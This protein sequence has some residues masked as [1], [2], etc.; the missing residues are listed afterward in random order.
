M[1]RAQHRRAFAVET[2][3]GRRFDVAMER[4]LAGSSFEFRDVTF[5]LADDGAVCCDI[6]SSWQLENVTLETATRDFSAA[7][8]VLEE[9]V[10]LSAP[11]ASAV[12]GRP[13]RFELTD[14]DG[15][16]SFLIGSLIDGALVWAPGFRVR[17]S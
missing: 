16:A 9:L 12:D 7:K 14:Y 4:F 8:R 11:F 3:E 2:A 17:D 15:M 6:D 10:A 5:R 13:V 1:T